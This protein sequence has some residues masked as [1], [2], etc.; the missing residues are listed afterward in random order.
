MVN[1][2]A[3]S[4]APCDKIKVKV[5]VRIDP[6]GCF[7]VHSASM[8]ESLPPAPEKEIEPM[9][10]TESAPPAGGDASQP[11]ADGVK[12]K[13]TVNGENKENTET[14]EQPMDAEGEE[15]QVK[16]T[17]FTK[18]VEMALGKTATPSKVP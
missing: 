14:N 6:N 16:K 5:K 7:T 1:A 2:A 10:T 12:K 13:E 15:K 18:I 11:P 8:V 3:P 4:D 17:T 9:D